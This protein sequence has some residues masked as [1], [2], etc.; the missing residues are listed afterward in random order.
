MHIGQ[1]KL[2]VDG[3]D[4]WTNFGV[5]GR[6]GYLDIFLKMPKR[7][8]SLTHDWLD[9]NGI[10]VDLSKIFLDKRDLP[11]K[12]VMV[13]NNE[14]DFWAKHGQFQALWTQPGLRRLTVRQFNRDFYV[15]YQDMPEASKSGNLKNNSGKIF[16]FFTLLLSEP[17]PSIEEVYFLA[18]DDG[19]FI[20]T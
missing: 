12:M 15:H 2:F 3:T 10:D 4:L 20:I 9:T 18:D 1:G 11:L 6:K 13:G 17:K 19:V 7:K 5:I 14:E 16:F 8:E